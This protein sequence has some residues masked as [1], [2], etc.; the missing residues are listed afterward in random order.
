MA[1]STVAFA[2]LHGETFNFWLRQTK[3]AKPVAVQARGQLSLSLR[4]L[5]LNKTRIHAVAK[6][7]DAGGKANRHLLF[8]ILVLLYSS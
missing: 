7:L 1:T 4:V 5:L 2:V 8:S 3:N 6:E